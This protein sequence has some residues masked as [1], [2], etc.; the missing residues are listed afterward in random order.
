M[1]TQPTDYDYSPYDDRT[2]M[3]RE[4]DQY[5]ASSTRVPAS[6]LV[7]RPL[8]LSERTGPV[9]L[10]RKWNAGAHAGAHAGTMDLCR[11]AENGPR[12]LGQLISVTGRVTDEDGAPVSGVVIELWQANAAGK[13]IHE[14]DDHVAPLDPNFIG[15]GR[16]LTDEDGRYQ[17]FTIKPGAY[18]VLYSGWWWRPPH[19]HFSILGRS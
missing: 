10:A 14:M 4:I 9:E 18:P 15:Q 17:V 19:I 5:T 11:A 1:K 12:A 2:Q 6:P 13:Y 7:P 8:T 3:F 16:L